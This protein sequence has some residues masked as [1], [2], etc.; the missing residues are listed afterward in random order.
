[1]YGRATRTSITVVSKF[2]TKTWGA[3]HARTVDTRSSSPH[4]PRAPGNEAKG[5]V[6]RRLYHVHVCQ[7]EKLVFV[8]VFHSS[9]N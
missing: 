8:L 1:M 5:D 6:V 3:A 9:L 2:P 4:L 7:R